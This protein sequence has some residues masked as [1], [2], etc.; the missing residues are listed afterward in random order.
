MVRIS[1]LE[2]VRLLRENSRT[3]FVDLARHFR[4]S[5]TAVR[6][7]MKKL[8]EKGVIKKYTIEVD[9]KKVGM[10]VDTLI[11]VD[12][13][14]EKYIKILEK[15]RDMKEVKRLCTS[16]GDH[17]LMIEC[18]FGNSGELSRFLRMLEKTDGITKVCP[19]IINE[20]M[21]C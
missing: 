11:G 19:A 13:R 5:E 10:D 12:T 2:L 1:N 17:M 8:E 6:K 7:R 21:K 3:S 15:L 18:W 9:L 20:N 14:P 4:V 16:T